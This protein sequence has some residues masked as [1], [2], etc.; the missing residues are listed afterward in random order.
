MAEMTMDEMKEQL[1]TVGDLLL[2]LLP[3]ECMMIAAAMFLVYNAVDKFYLDL[4][5]TFCIMEEGVEFMMMN[6]E[7]E[8]AKR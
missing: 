8:E 6:R 2:R 5:E 3:D 1:G 4:E 7:R